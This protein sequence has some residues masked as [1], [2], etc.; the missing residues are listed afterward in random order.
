MKTYKTVGLLVFILL[1]G[2]LPMFAQAGQAQ[3]PSPLS[4]E[5]RPSFD[6]PLGDSAQWFNFGGALELG[7]NYKIPRSLFFVTGG[8]EYT[9]SP[10]LAAASVSLAALR[11]G[12]GVQLPLAN[13]ISAFGYAAA[14]YYFA[15]YNDFSGNAND[16][17]LAGGIGLKFALMPTFTFE[18]GAGYKNFLGLY[19]GISADAGI[20]VALGNLGG[21]VG[22]PAIELR[23]AFPVFYKHYDD[24]PI[25]DLQLQS[26]LKVP[27]NDMRAQVYIKEFMDA[28]K[29]V[30]VPGTLEPGQSE[31]VDLYALFTDKV[32]AVTEGTKVA[33]EISVTYKVEGQTYESKR[34]ETL[35]IWGR[36]AMTWDDN[37][38]AAA[39]VT[40]KD[41]GVLNFARSVTSYVRSKE[42]RSIC[43]NLQ[44][45]IA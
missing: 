27:A 35:T 32:L 15:T 41:P 29:T 45:A 16:P 10:I 20:D 11:I 14:G 37:R 3:V 24:H 7:L 19:Q 26:N 30:P 42:N 22:I 44:A 21:S 43:D 4:I 38:K 34:I 5:V 40:S 18:V 9:Y 8:L 17:C 33:A 31:K 36:N 25:G 1:A 23:P 28:P 6:A 39:Y 13:G 2:S 12:G